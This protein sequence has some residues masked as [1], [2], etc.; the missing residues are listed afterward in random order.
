MPG[1]PRQPVRLIGVNAPFEPKI[2]FGQAYSSRN[3]VRENVNSHHGAGHS[4]GRQP[5][6]TQ[7]IVKPVST[8]EQTIMTSRLSPELQR[9]LHVATGPPDNTGRIH[10]APL[11][12]LESI[13]APNHVL[14]EQQRGMHTAVVPTLS[15]QWQVT[16][17]RG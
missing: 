6:N 16:S 1:N 4:E 13:S 15:G 14:R 12:T 17:I 8:R 10:N 7:A 9:A 5:Q 11:P 3:S 2:Q